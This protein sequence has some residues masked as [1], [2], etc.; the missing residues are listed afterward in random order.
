M[1]M[2]LTGARNAELYK[3]RWHQI[4]WEKGAAILE[5]HKTARKTGKSR[6]I[7]FPP[8]AMKLLAWLFRHRYGS[9]AVELQRILQAAPDRCLGIREVAAKMRAKG[10]TYRQ[11]Y[12]ARRLIGA[13][14]DRVGGWGSRGRVVYRLPQ[15]PVEQPPDYANFVFLSIKKRPW[16]RVALATKFG[17]IRQKLGLPASAKMYGIRHMFISDAMRRGLP[18]KAIATLVGHVNTRMIESTY[19]HVGE[20][21]D[22]LRRAA[23]QAIGQAPVPQNVSKPPEGPGLNE[24]PAA[25]PLPAPGSAEELIRPLVRQITALEQQ[26]EKAKQPSTPKL[27]QAHEVAFAA[28]QW[29]L[30]ERPE[31][32]QARDEDVYVFLRSRPELEGKLPGSFTTLGRYIRQHRR[33]VDGCAKYQRRRK[34]APSHPAPKGGTPH[35]QA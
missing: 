8:P 26:L 23:L 3:L 31:L 17:R 15:H 32:A 7:V 30:Q 28:Y 12:G 16:N 22:Y 13:T 25:L 2:R 4:D 19:C 34:N 6:I 5:D 18:L 14:L 20:D 21:F 1:M 27:N 10:F 33:L 29:A 35:E 9:A 24:T 11:I